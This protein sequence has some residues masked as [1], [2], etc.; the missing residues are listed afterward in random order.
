MLDFK[1]FICLTVCPTVIFKLRACIL[2]DRVSPRKEINK[3]Y[4]LLR[5]SMCYLISWCGFQVCSIKGSVPFWCQILLSVLGYII[6]LG[7][8]KSDDLAFSRCFGVARLS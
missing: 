8:L 2:Y 4:S 6:H 7:S 5:K 3:N 1:R